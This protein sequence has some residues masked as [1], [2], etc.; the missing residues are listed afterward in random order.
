IT[1]STEPAQIQ[2]PNL[3]EPREIAHNSKEPGFEQEDPLAFN[4]RTA[5]QYQV[6]QWTALAGATSDTARKNAFTKYAAAYSAALIAYDGGVV[7][8]DQ[9]KTFGPALDHFEKE[10]T[11]KGMLENARAIKIAIEKGKFL[12][13]LEISSYVGSSATTSSATTSKSSSTSVPAPT[14]VIAD[15]P[16]VAPEPPAPDKPAPKHEPAADLPPPTPVTAPEPARPG[17]VITNPAK[18][19]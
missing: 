8:A 11:R 18:P 9:Q 2:L 4:H 1:H 13:T 6:N 5:L 14:P 7:T 16:P 10:A 17:R 19:K 12:R 15:R 3:T